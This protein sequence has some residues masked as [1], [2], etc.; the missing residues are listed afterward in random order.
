MKNDAFKNFDPRYIMRVKNM[1]AAG[2]DLKNILIVFLTLLHEELADLI[3]ESEEIIDESECEDEEWET[4]RCFFKSDIHTINMIRNLKTIVAKRKISEG[5]FKKGAAIFESSSA[6]ESS[7]KVL[8]EEVDLI[9]AFEVL[10]RAIFE[11]EKSISGVDYLSHLPKES[12]NNSETDS[13]ELEVIYEVDNSAMIDCSQASLALKFD[14]HAAFSSKKDKQVK[15]TPPK[16]IEY[17][18]IKQEDSQGETESPSINDALRKSRNERGSSSSS[19]QKS[20][21]KNIEEQGIKKKKEEEAQI[22]QP[23]EDFS[24]STLFGKSESSNQSRRYKYEEA[25]AKIDKRE[26]GK[27]ARL[28]YSTVD[29]VKKQKVDKVDLDQLKSEIVGKRREFLARLNSKYLSAI[30]NK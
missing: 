29:F 19:G 8:A 22:T 30:I 6:T 11:L 21:R 13:K 20:R 7:E 27:V 9:K 24:Y 4:I 14:K 5:Y 15:A 25:P 2:K 10:I 23:P 16:S 18:K 1:H 3:N 12:E 28:E 26:E 17:R